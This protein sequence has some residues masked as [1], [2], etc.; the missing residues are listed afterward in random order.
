MQ[1]LRVLM[2][3]VPDSLDLNLVAKEV[4]KISEVSNLHHVH[5]WQINDNEIH[6]EAH[7]DFEDDL[8]LSKANLVLKQIRDIL[9]DHFG[10][11]HCVLQP[12]FN[13]HDAKELVIDEN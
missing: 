12:E 10:I 6:L 1:T 5:V 4:Q 7:V 8:S 13:I 2:Q 11:D 3:F 9:H